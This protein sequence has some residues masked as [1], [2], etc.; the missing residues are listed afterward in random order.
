[1]SGTINKIRRLFDR[2][3]NVALSTEDV[4]VCILE[5]ELIH[6]MHE[7]EGVIALEMT[8]KSAWNNKEELGLLFKKLE[9]SALYLVAM[10]GRRE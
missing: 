10:G 5:P 7:G 6:I 1:M 8:L 3:H 4:N 2:K 9:T